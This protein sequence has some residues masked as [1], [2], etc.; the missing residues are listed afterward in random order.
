M[1]FEKRM[2]NNLLL[3]SNIN[4]GGNAIDHTHVY[5]Y[6]GHEIKIEKDNQIYEIQRRINVSWPVFG[7]FG[8]ILKSDIAISLK[9]EVYEQC[10]YQY[11]FIE[12]I[13]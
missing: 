3:S 7:K 5:E 10:F 9:R 4:L 11:K 13:L 8:N 1:N 6:L 2:M 12:Q